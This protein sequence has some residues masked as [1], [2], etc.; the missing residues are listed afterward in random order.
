MSLRSRTISL[1]ICVAACSG[2]NL[3]LPSDGE[4]AHITALQSNMTGTVGQPLEDSLVVEVTDPGGRPVPE[5][6]VTFVPPAGGVVEPAGPVTTDSEG[7]AAVHYI[8]STVAGSQMVE[9]RAPIVPADNAVAVFAVIANPE[10]AEALVKDERNGDGQSAQV[11]TVLPESLAVKAVDRFGNGVPGIEV[12]W[13]AEDGQVS[14]ASVVTG[15][16]GRAATARTLGDDPGPYPTVARAGTLDGSPITFNATA[17]AAPRPQL[18]LVAQPSTT[19]AAG[20][21]LAEQPVLQLQDA[22]GA[23]L[24]RDDVSVTAQIADGGGS[25]SGRTTVRS[26]ANGSVRFTDLELRGEIGTRTLIFAADGFT[27]VTS[28]AIVVQPGPPSD[29][30]SLSVGNGTAGVTTPITVA[31]RDEFGNRIPGAAGDLSLRITGANPADGL[32][33]TDN[34]NGSYSSSYIPIHS[35]TDEITL[36]F[37][38]ARLGSAQSV[39]SPGPSN[40]GASTAEVNR[41]GVFFVRIDVLVTVRDAQGN[42]VGH[43]GDLVQISAN[44][45][46]PRSCAPPDG[47]DDTCLDNGDGTYTDAFILIADDVTVDISVNGVPISG[48]P[49]HRPAD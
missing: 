48:S 11:S 27:P 2:D 18:V 9:A 39:V 33:V 23:P 37:R 7:R 5:V 10:P 16:D 4:P 31:L 14:P 21:P 35:G 15:A 45:S 47:R 20:V 26:D 49:F 32:T 41:S 38:G 43:G 25:L 6:E 22:T 36:E 1:L 8:L 28:A 29:E 13:D 44:G 12:T 3:L 17:F 40:P 34:G 30:S 19:A 24:L 46:A 42:V